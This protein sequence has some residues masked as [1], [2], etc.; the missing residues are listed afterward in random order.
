[1]QE[2]AGLVAAGKGA[3]R[4]KLRQANW[5]SKC[6]RELSSR[7]REHTF[8]NFSKFAANFR[9]SWQRHWQQSE[10]SEGRSR[11]RAQCASVRYQTR[12][13][14]EGGGGGGEKG[15]HRCWDERAR[16]LGACVCA[17]VRLCECEQQFGAGC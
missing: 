5:E 1:M 16:A 10:E 12:A 7:K 8:S 2:V 6:N 3:T 9:Q 11:R 14:V 4:G 17:C 15:D 13:P